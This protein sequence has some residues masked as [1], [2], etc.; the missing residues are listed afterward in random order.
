MLQTLLE[1]S[2]T[3]NASQQGAGHD[4]INAEEVE[5][6][7]R[8]RDSH[9]ACTLSSLGHLFRYCQVFKKKM[10]DGGNQEENG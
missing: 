9:L 5:S 10:D 2:H 1:G 6:T 8:E 7:R 3:D 4:E